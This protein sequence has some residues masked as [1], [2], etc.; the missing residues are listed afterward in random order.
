MSTRGR[1]ISLHPDA[2]TLNSPSVTVMESHFWLKHSSISI[3]LREV[4][5]YSANRGFTLHYTTTSWCTGEEKS[6]LREQLQERLQDR[7]VY[8]QLQ[9]LNKRC[10][11][12]GLVLMEQQSILSTFTQLMEPLRVQ[13]VS[14]GETSWMIKYYRICFGVRDETPSFLTLESQLRGDETSLTEHVKHS[15]WRKWE[16]KA[17]AHPPLTTRHSCGWSLKTHITWLRSCLGSI[18]KK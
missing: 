8:R 1:L 2:W 13:C 17:S 4:V 15:H 14:E 16:R 3:C 18:Q 12:D 9:F 6:V 10:R 5:K 7:N 11:N